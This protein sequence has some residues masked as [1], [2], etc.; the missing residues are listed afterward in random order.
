MYDWLNTLGLGMF[1]KS[2]CVDRVNDAPQ[3]G[4][5]KFPRTVRV[6][7][8]A[9]IFRPP[10]SHRMVRVFYYALSMPG[11]HVDLMG[12]WRDADDWW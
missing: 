4:A 10:S 1:P 3:A 6:E 7:R 11:R 8:C 12:A 5:P 9:R 2:W